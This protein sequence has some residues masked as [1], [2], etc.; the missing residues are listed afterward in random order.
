MES[1]FASLTKDLVFR[2]SF[3][4]LAA[5]KRSIF[6]YV[7][8]FYNRV[9][10]H[11]SLGSIAPATFE[12]RQPRS[13]VHE[14]WESPVRGRLDVRQGLADGVPADAE[15]VSDLTDAQAI[16]VQLPNAGEVVHGTHRCPPE[17]RRP[18]RE[19]DRCTVD[20]NCV[21]RWTRIPRRLPDVSRWS[22]RGWPWSGT[23][24][25]SPGYSSRG[26]AGI[27]VAH[28]SRLPA[29]ARR[30]KRCSRRRGTIGFLDFK[31]TGAPPLLS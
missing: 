24:H 12:S 5:A 31:L 20:Q 2:D 6:E 3:A 15:L 11:S 4:T 7:E 21:P 16:A 9:R 17:Q 1:F 30:T 8:V 14:P 26:F 28:S 23:A 18:Y 10:L 29:K 27:T 19:G 25:S 13:S 22:A